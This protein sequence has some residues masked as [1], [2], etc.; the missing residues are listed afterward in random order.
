M[1]EILASIRRIIADEEPAAKS[2][3][4]FI[5][6]ALPDE[7]EDFST[8]KAVGAND[9]LDLAAEEEAALAGVIPAKPVT[10]VD[11]DDLSFDT[12]EKQA[13][14]PEPPGPKKNEWSEPVNK[15]APRPQAPAQQAY[16]PS[17]QNYAAPGDLVS[18]H[19]GAAVSAAF[20]TL[21]NSIFSSE[22]RTI[23]DLTKDMLNPLLKQWLDDN[24]PS[25]VERIVRDEIERVARGRR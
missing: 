1:E 16:A 18:T 22:P 15:P 19:T 4:E 14:A 17:P 7:A 3:G 20:N 25:L 8:P 5:A 11:M 10:P 6:E 2:N 13:I 21:A 9:V 24:L 12:N 23:E